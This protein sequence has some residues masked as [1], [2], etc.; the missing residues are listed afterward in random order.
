MSLESITGPV[1]PVVTAILE[2]V[3]QLA[4]PLP[5]Q[6]QIDHVCYRVEHF[7]QYKQIRDA[8]LSF[9]TLATESMINGRPIASIKLYEPLQL[10][11]TASLAAKWGASV[12][13]PCI[14]V[15]NLLKKYHRPFADGLN[16]LIHNPFVSSLCQVII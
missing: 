4:L 1:A 6:L 9:G 5:S 12:S 14:E 8:L 2:Y 15:F 11:L 16:K 3:A 13:I 7:A 10:S